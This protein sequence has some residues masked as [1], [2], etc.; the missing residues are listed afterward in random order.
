M[1]LSDVN[2]DIMS[3]LGVGGNSPA[4]DP[5]SKYL[6]GPDINEILKLGP[7][8]T[9]APDTEPNLPE[10][11]ASALG[12][13]APQTTSTPTLSYDSSVDDL[14]DYGTEM[15]DAGRTGLN[16]QLS[17]NILPREDL[18][19]QLTDIQA[20]KQQRR[21]FL[22]DKTTGNPLSDFD[23]AKVD[24]E[25]R[26]K[27]P[28]G[29]AKR[30]LIDFL[31]SAG[32]ALK[33]Q[34][35]T[36]S[37]MGDALKAAAQKRDLSQKDLD[38]LTNDERVVKDLI[39]NSNTADVNRDKIQSQNNL[40]L[41][42]EGRLNTSRAHAMKMDEDNLAVKKMNAGTAKDK[43]DQAN[44]LLTARLSQY[45][46]VG[47]LSPGVRENTINGEVM[48]ALLNNPQL[49]E[50]YITHRNDPDMTTWPKELI[51]G[52]DKAY[53]K[54]SGAWEAAKAA[55]VGLVKGTGFLHRTISIPHPIYGDILAA[56]TINKA[57]GEQTVKPLENPFSKGLLVKATKQDHDV[58]NR[59]NDLISSFQT[60]FSDFAGLRDDQRNDLTGYVNGSPLLTALRNAEILEVGWDFDSSDKA[61]KT[62]L[63]A[64]QL[65]VERLYQYSG[66]QINENE[67]K[68]IKA[69]LPNLQRGPHSF[70]TA[71]AVHYYT[72]Q[73]INIRQSD[74]ILGKPLDR[75]E[76]VSK[77]IGWMI[78]TSTRAAMDH[79]FEKTPLYND[80]E[81]KM[82]IND[83]RR[84]GA[85]RP[86]E[87]LI[88][89]LREK[90]G[91]W[92]S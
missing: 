88:N 68:S 77:A 79:K 90:Y 56:Q 66:K 64:S 30:F 2:S 6:R 44:K 33:G 16:A 39:N 65:W 45:A 37:V 18:I 36:F 21:D 86:S 53:L 35:P 38:D 24:V 9:Q 63:D 25:Q 5:M 55:K 3:I 80:Q 69:F 49:R 42:T 87:A 52:W 26:Y 20:R 62:L 12:R 34:A 74:K 78:R 75:K 76:D 82:I 23:R 4:Q 13:P 17:N 67:M 27:G 84:T 59:S 54:I 83:M 1:S 28:G 11:V 70:L 22:F 15:L 32:P 46:Q 47:S 57:T 71:S 50:L 72:T 14:K 58:I 51:D 8:N 85:D 81:M 91:T 48:G 31:G 43:A 7:Q 41:L 61:Y 29:F 40:K 10:S 92:G 19:K 60:V 73:L 89:L